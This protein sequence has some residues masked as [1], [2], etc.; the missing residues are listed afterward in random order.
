[1]IEVDV[2]GKALELGD[3]TGRSANVVM[4]GVLS[5]CAPFD[6][7]P[8]EVWHKALQRINAK[9]EVW[10]IN[11]AAFNLGREFAAVAAIG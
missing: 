11:Y 5:T 8:P 6:V 2:L 1:M 9:P 4:M 3:H 7:F 10:D